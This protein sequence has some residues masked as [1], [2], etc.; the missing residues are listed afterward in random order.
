M[1]VVPTVRHPHAAIYWTLVWM[2]A[3]VLVFLVM[4]ST[5]GADDPER[6]PQQPAPATIVSPFDG[7]FSAGP[8]IGAEPYV[9]VGSNVDQG[10]L[11]GHVEV[12][13]R[14]TPIYSLLK[15]TITQVLVA[16]GDVVECGQPLFEV[17][18]EV[19][20]PAPVK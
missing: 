17:R 20:D 12:C 1:F 6:P 9:S 11:V 10:D 8:Y 18:M 5:A 15:G 3:V 7:A 2:L 16:D 19:I 4:T 13:G 14:M